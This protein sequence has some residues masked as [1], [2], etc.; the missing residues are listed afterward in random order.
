MKDNI[1]KVIF[2]IISL[3]LLIAMIVI[4]S[5][6]IKDKINTSKLIPMIGVL[7]IMLIVVLLVWIRRKNHSQ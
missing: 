5:D 4:T 7:S 3:G 6:N 1:I 2:L